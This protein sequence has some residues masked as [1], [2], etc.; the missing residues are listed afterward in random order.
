MFLLHVALLWLG[1]RLNLNGDVELDRMECREYVEPFTKNRWIT[2]NYF[3]VQ[4]NKSSTPFAAPPSEALHIAT[5]KAKIVTAE[6]VM[7]D[8]TESGAP[9]N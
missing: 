7:R 6:P 9:N 4:G 1:Q 3:R 8:L 2:S 5:H